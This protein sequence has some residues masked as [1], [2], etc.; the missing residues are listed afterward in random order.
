MKKHMTG[1]EWEV[2][3]DSFLMLKRCRR[4]VRAHPRK[5]YLFASACCGR[6][7]HLLDDE[8]SRAAVG[9]VARYAEGLAS[10]DQL[11]AAYEAAEAAHAEAF[12]R[13]GKVGACP[14]WAAQFAASSDPWFAATRAGNFAYVAAGDPVLKPG[15]EKAA[16]AILLRCIFGPL[17]FREAAFD[18]SRITSAVV[19]LAQAIYGASAFDRMPELADALQM[20][21]CTDEDILGHAR[22]TGLHVRGCWVLDLILKR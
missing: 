14:E 3:D 5:A 7:V 20:A 9:T 19:Q 12:R 1:A 10:G 8:R 22:G 16:Q 2:S 21:G 4:V 15:S 13:K 18:L 17:P 6:I 11:R